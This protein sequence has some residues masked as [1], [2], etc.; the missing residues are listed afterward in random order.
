MRVVRVDE[1]PGLRPLPHQRERAGTGS[2]PLH[3]GSA[4]TL[5]TPPSAV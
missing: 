1:G 2:I 4:N 3:S 5:S